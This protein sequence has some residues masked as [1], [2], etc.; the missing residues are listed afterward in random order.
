[1]NDYNFDYMNYLTKIP[2]SQMNYNKEK[3]KYNVQMLNQSSYNIGQILDP[4][5]GF[6]RGNLFRNLYDGYKNYMPQEINA[7]NEREALL[8]Q[9]RQYNFALVELDLHLDTHPNDTNA[10]KLYNDYNNI[11]KQ[12]ASKYE[13]MYGPLTLDSS[14]LNNNSWSWINSPWPWEEDK[15][16]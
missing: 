7:Q 15:N 12:I 16:V 2:G 8:N 6:T 13:S 4:K 11:L 3:D 5:E 1:M 9:W 14:Y 10:I